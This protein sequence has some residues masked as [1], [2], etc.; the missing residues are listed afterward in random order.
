MGCS[1]SR[2][3]VDTTTTT[4]VSQ[5]TTHNLLAVLRVQRYPRPF[6]SLFLPLSLFRLARGSLLPLAAG[7]FSPFSYRMRERELPRSKV[8]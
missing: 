7:A 5:D 4:N 2:E 8:F 3:P 6:F 1:S